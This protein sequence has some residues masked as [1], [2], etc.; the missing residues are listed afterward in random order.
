[1]V[2][3]GEGAAGVLDER[4]AAANVYDFLRELVRAVARVLQGLAYAI[5]HPVL[6]GL[7]VAA[8]VH[9][10][11]EGGGAVRAQF[12]HGDRGPLGHRG[13]IA[14]GEQ[15]PGEGDLAIQR[16]QRG[17]QRARRAAQSP[18]GLSKKAVV[19][20]LVGGL[21]GVL[22]VLA[23]R[24]KH[25]RSNLQHEHAALG[26]HPH[27]DRDDDLLL[28]AADPDPQEVPSGLAALLHRSGLVG[29]EGP[30][31]VGSE[32]APRQPV[33]WQEHALVDL[34]LAQPVPHHAPGV[35]RGHAQTGEQR[36]DRLQDHSVTERLL[37]LVGVRPQ[38]H[39][40]GPGIVRLACAAERMRLV[41]HHQR[42]VLLDP[43]PLPQPLE[44]A[45]FR[46]LGWVSRHVGEVPRMQL[47]RKRPREQPA[48]RGDTT[49]HENH[50]YQAHP[51]MGG[52]DLGA[53]RTGVGEHIE[54]KAR[55]DPLGERLD[56]LPFQFTEGH[57]HNAK[58]QVAHRD[59]PRPTHVP[60]EE[61]PPVGR[62]RLLGTTDLRGEE[63]QHRWHQ[64][65]RE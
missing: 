3:Y 26:V 56:A 44:P 51:G 39:G 2:A 17:R 24:E 19:A 40:E 42:G 1:M 21:V 43:D 38:L 6:D 22:E 10:L 41:V 45:A 36:A 47:G 15:G 65:D 23:D 8:H 50:R 4:A 62:R 34:Q 18:A 35:R 16:H 9:V 58:Q 27:E 49:R 30:F 64:E 46:P 13:A 25:M 52:P 37:H 5:G 33:H 61:P 7:Q 60:G 48:L 29:E 57:Q 12:A 53:A 28:P 59:P 63:Q 20:V 32:V 55:Q 11:E 14:A 31:V 54:N